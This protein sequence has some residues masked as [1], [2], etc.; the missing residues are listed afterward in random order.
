MFFYVAD[1]YMSESWNDQSRL[2]YDSCA[3]NAYDKESQGVGNYLTGAPG[4]R[5]CQTATD[6]SKNMSEIAHYQKVYQ[7]KCKI[8]EE[9]K[10]FRAPLTNPRLIHQVYTRPYLGS[11]QGPG[12]ASLEQKDTESELIHGVDTRGG[13]RK[14]CDVLS[15]VSIDRFESLPEYGN[16]QRVQHVVEPWIRGGDNTRDHVRRINYE[17]RLKNAMNNQVINRKTPDQAQSL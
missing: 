14:A 13:P 5:E 1:K 2:R 6:Y 17:R 11:Y 9:T 3:R 4:W 16:P 8:D 7:D 15:G 10:L 12:Q